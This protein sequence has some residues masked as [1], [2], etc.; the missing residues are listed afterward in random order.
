MKQRFSSLDVKVITQE[1]ASELVNLRVSNIYDLSSRIFLFKL[2]KPDHRKQLVVDSGF[3]CHVTQYSRATASAPSPFV[4]RMRK[5]LK[6]RRVTSVQQLGT[7]R[8]IDF[9]FSDG[10]Y[11][12]FLEFFAGGNIIL[13]DREYTILALFRQVAAGDGQEE[14]TRVGL[15][16]TVDNKQNYHG[17]PDITTQRVRETVQ[18]AKDLFAAEG[19]SN[20]PKKSKKKNTDVLRK[21]LSQGF[22]EYPPLLLDHAF[23][24]KG[25]DPATP[26][27][28]VLSDD[29]DLLTRVVEVLEVAKAETDNLSVGQGHPG[30]IVAKEDTRTKAKEAAEEKEDN[31]EASGKKPPALLYEDFHPFKPRQFEGKPGVTILEFENFNKTVDEYFSSIE[32]QKLESRLTER[33]EAAKRKL[34][35]VRQEHAKRIGALQEVQGLHIRKAAA[36][37]DNVYRVQEAMDAVNGLIAQGMDWVEIAR[38][39]EMEQSRGN[40]V[41]RIIKLPLKLHE[42]TITLVLGEAGDEEQGDGEELFSDDEDES[43][44]E[45]EKEDD[46]NFEKRADV[47]VVDIDLGLSPWANATQYYEQKKQAAVKEQRTTQSSAKALK[48]H[49]KKVTQDLKRNLKQEKQVLRPARKLFWFEKFLFF[50]SSEGYLVLGGRDA[51]QSEMLYRRYLKKGDVFVH[52]DL[53]GATPMIVKNRAGTPNAPIPPSTLSQAG[54]LCVA[55]SSAWDSKAIMSAYWVSASQVSKTAEV[56]G[57]VPT[58]EFVIKGEKNFLAPSQLVLGFAVM[59]QVSKESLR[60]HKLRQFD[61]PAAAEPIAGEGDAPAAVAE[62]KEPFEENS[63]TAEA[64]KSGSPDEP[65]EQEQEQVSD[66]DE[67][68]E[69]DK[70]ITERNPLQRGLS[71]PAQAEAGNSN[72]A[73]D[74]PSDDENAEEEGEQEQQSPQTEKTA[75]DE[76]LLE[77]SLASTEDQGKRQLSARERRLLRKGQPLDSQDTS[78]KEAEGSSKKQGPNGAP[79]KPTNTKQAG[80]TR[81]KKGK[82]KKAAAKYA[83]QDEDERELALRL[84]GVNSE[85][86]AKAAAEAEA[87]AKREQ[88]AEAQKKHRRAQ[89]ERAAEAERKRQALFEGGADDYDEETAAAEAADLEWIPAMIGTP[90]PDDD[91]LAAIPYKI[92]LQ[93]GTVKKGKAVKEI[94]GRWVAETTT[95]KVKKEHAEDAGINRAAAEKLREREGE[96]IKGW[97]DTEII[98]SV[99]VASGGDK[100]KGKGGGGG[101]G[102]G[103]NKGDQSLGTFSYYCDFLYS[104][105]MLKKRFPSFPPHLENFVDHIDP[106]PR[107]ACSFSLMLDTRIVSRSLAQWWADECNNNTPEAAAIEEAAQLLQTSDIPV[108]FP[109]ETVD[110]VQGIYKAKQRPSDNPLIIHVDSLG[111]LERILNPVHHSPTRV[112][113]T[114]QNKLPAIYD[115]V[116]SRFWP[117]PLTILVPNPSG[118]PLAN[119]VTSNLTTFGVRMP[120]SPLARLLIHVADR[121]LAAPSANASTKPS[122]T[123]AEHVYHDLQGRIELIL[124]GGPCGVGVESTVIDGLSDPPAILRPGGIGIEELRQCPGWE[125]VQVGY[126]DGTLD[127]KEVPRAPGMKYRHYSPKAR[128]VLFEP[129]SADEG[130]RNHIRKDLEDSAIG[131]HSIGVVRT[132][133]WKQGMGLVSEEEIQSGLKPVES[134]MEN[135]VSFPVPVEDKIK[136]CVVTKQTFDCH[137]GPDIK[138]I[139]QGLFSALRAMDEVEV[140]VIYVEG[141]P[142][143]QGDLAAAVMNRLRK[144]AGAELRV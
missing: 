138:S 129:E 69:E 103:G 110:A 24:V 85:K 10:Q 60:N 34:D 20:A 75:A 50:V 46:E 61:E 8:V 139:A 130:I 51:M 125:N 95:G 64:D 104:F 114:A 76:P 1:L 134:L 79:A 113:S 58:G 5:F 118:S 91:I 9:A 27:E 80:S 70:A 88:E 105:N 127:V 116:I 92:K 41:A 81:G 107:L 89:H 98:N 33:E 43:E 31:E 100:G 19:G 4:T 84:L 123:A 132:R 144:A 68:A 97:K 22:P 57:L 87:K 82:A 120:S 73:N 112:T 17:V 119:E 102:G 55:T 101:G 36:I 30:Y 142:D 2:A 115:S 7:D 48:S 78:P 77:E 86:A 137:L 25:L 62:G 16:Y 96:L 39:I 141:V 117:G 131:A 66:S 13:T 136:A 128:V 38:L 126:H 67:E 26:L 6:S 23:A 124:D 63:E 45:D 37:E 42:N 28:E 135:L 12:L 121:P 108:A 106:T 93:P 14:E 40:P 133:N 32:S 143:Q 90:H 21:A 35:A 56:G 11:H 94:I 122:P 65:K 3:R 53:Q 71:E 140:D 111:M 15:K 99:P 49:E 59:F 44:S 74:S 54:N 18:K 29:G 47:L 83:D 72:D 109:T 52:A